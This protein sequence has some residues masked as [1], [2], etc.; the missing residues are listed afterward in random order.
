MSR[1]SVSRS[2]YQVSWFILLGSSVFGFYFGS[3]LVISSG[4]C[5]VYLFRVLFGERGFPYGSLL[6]LSFVSFVV[7]GCFARIRWLGI[8]LFNSCENSASA[9][10]CGE[11]SFSF[12]LS[13]SFLLLCSFGIAVPFV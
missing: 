3:I 4:H 6:F 1:V 2:F 13:F 11:F 12:F 7:L 5:C 9:D 8:V 10:F